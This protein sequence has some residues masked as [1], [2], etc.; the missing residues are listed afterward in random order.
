MK[1]KGKFKGVTTQITA[2]SIALALQVFAQQS[3]A[4]VLLEHLGILRPLNLQDS[5]KITA[6]GVQTFNLSSTME[7]PITFTKSS[8][9][10]IGLSSLEFLQLLKAYSQNPQETLEISVDKLNSDSFEITGLRVG[11]P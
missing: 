3:H 6:A 7:E 4:E 9:E 2:I 10:S 1:T 5:F 8:I 11:T